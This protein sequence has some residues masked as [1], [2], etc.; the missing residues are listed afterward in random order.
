MV[1]HLRHISKQPREIGSSDAGS[2]ESGYSNSQSANTMDCIVTPCI[3]LSCGRASSHVRSGENSLPSSIKREHPRKKISWEPS[4][5]SQTSP[6]RMDTGVSDSQCCVQQLTSQGSALTTSR[7]RQMENTSNIS[8]EG[9]T[10]G[11]K[12]TS[13]RATTRSV[14]CVMSVR[15]EES[16]AAG[17]I[18]CTVPRCVER[19]TFRLRPPHLHQCRYIQPTG[20]N[21]C[22]ILTTVLTY[23]ADILEGL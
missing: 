2:S 1:A 18:V 12:E 19:R 15:Q 16:M 17:L 7:H 22:E 21:C 8:C 20:G 10:H 23:T 11:M 4:S 14:R 5:W 13:F 3:N 9:E 6:K